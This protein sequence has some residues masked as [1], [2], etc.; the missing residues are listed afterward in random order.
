MKKGLIFTHIYLLWLSDN[1]ITIQE[2]T[3]NNVTA[4]DTFTLVGKEKKMVTVV[5]LLLLQKEHSDMV[6][7][8][9]FPHSMPS[10]TLMKTPYGHANKFKN[11]NL[12]FNMK[13][14]PTSLSE[15]FTQKL[16]NSS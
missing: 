4:R 11:F 3:C 1:R 10:S 7:T 13:F 12:N 5:T 14:D 8:A 15:D 16:C 2:V 9:C 6:L